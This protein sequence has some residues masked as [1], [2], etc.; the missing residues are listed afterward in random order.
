MIS[1]LLGFLGYSLL[2]ISQAVQKLGLLQM[3]ENRKKGISL[4]LLA[5]FGT[6][7]ASIVVF[8]GVALG[9]VA[10][11][12]AMA[13][14]GLAALAVFSHYVMKERIGVKEIAGI[15][16]IV[17]GAALIGLFSNDTPPSLVRLDVLFIMFAIAVFL[18]SLGWV[19]GGVKGKGIR[20]G[21]IIGSFSG[22]LG[23]FVPLFQKVSTS[24]LGKTWS[25]VQNTAGGDG[26]GNLLGTLLAGFLNPFSL[27]WIALSIISMVI[28]QF[29]Y[30]K[31]D[32][33]FIIPFF[34]CNCIIV[35]VVGG[36]L[37]F[38]EV[39]H[40]VQWFGVAFIL[41]GLILLTAR[42]RRK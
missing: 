15:V 33:I 21:I 39:L 35:P 3:K 30:K 5:T 11:V 20:L 1:I 26:G 19:W 8:A 10:L 25:L 29:A 14:T 27:I 38:G 17:F 34:S 12:G 22:G 6:S 41:G 24:E 37:C 9:N 18:Y 40:I 28:L 4:W 2:N 16:I 13:G 32:V 36:I 42:G 7:L 23:G 31:A